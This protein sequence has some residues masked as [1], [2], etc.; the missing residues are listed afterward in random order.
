MITILSASNRN[1]NLTTLFASRCKAFLE[2]KNIPSKLFCLAEIP[3]Q[4]SL[5]SVYDYGNS[6]FT[7]IGHDYIQPAEKIL[8][9]LPEYNG[10]MPGILK[11]FIDAME[12]KIF[13]GKKAGLIGVSA[14]RAGN[15]R[16][17]DHLTDVLHHLQVHVMPQK[18]PISNM[19]ALLDGEKVVD[20]PTLKGIEQQIDR[21][22]QY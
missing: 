22:I 20:G 8:F 12:P 1:E 4:I 17:M 16:G 5:K 13:V 18:L 2:E 15:L 7:Q 19:Y 11:L 9:V 14:G 21:L 6:V 3:D 10:S